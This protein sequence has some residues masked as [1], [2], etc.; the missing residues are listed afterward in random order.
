MGTCSTCT[1]LQGVSMGNSVNVPLEATRTPLQADIQPSKVFCQ[2]F[3]CR[4]SAPP[5]G[6]NGSPYSLCRQTPS[7]ASTKVCPFGHIIVDECC[8]PKLCPGSCT[9]TWQPAEA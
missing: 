2:A 4:Q 1:P 6:S 8:M 5:M 3:M 7:G 9:S